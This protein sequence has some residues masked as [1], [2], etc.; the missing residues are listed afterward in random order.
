MWEALTTALFALFKA[1][2]PFTWNKAHET[3]TAMDA[4]RVPDDIRRRWRD[5][6]RRFTGGLRP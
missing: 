4:P 1:L 5:K 2:I 6:L 3:D